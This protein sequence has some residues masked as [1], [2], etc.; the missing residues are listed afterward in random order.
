MSL[1]F[2]HSTDLG[3][4]A[5]GFGKFLGITS[6]TINTTNPRF[7]GLNSWQSGNVNL[8]GSETLRR[9][10]PASQQHATLIIGC[11]LRWEGSFSGDGDTPKGL[12]RLYGDVGTTAHLNLALTSA[13][14]IRVRLASGTGSTL[15]TSADGVLSIDTW[16][17]VAFKA[18][19]HD[20]TGAID[21]EVDGVN[22]LS[23]SGIDTKNGGTASVF[24][25]AEW[26][27]GGVSSTVRIRD[28]FLFNGA[29]AENN[30]FPPD[31]RVTGLLPDGDLTPEEWTHST[32][33]ASA[34]LID[35]NPPNGDTD[36]IESDVEGEITRVSFADLTDTTHTVLGVQTSVYARKDDAGDRSLRAAI[37][38]D[39]T[40]GNGGDHVL[41][42]SFS[43]Y[44]DCFDLDPDG[45]VA[46][47]PTS[48]NAA[49]VQVEVRP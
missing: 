44:V 48:V 3:D 37:F 40:A 8:N 31:V 41:S 13:G 36:Y 46:W 16:H 32:G 42:T 12:F 7:P 22:V 28:M 34:A 29:G 15:G 24:D 10:L 20:S 45:N 23:V 14:A 35:E 4:T 5:S 19:L 30:D 11:A 27:G 39:A 25:T 6:P 26:G 18:T 47:T 9:L 17:L 21:V 1:C 33:T 38:S 2:L 49:A 43:T